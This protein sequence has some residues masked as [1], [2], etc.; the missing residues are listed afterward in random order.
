[1]LRRLS[2]INWR[3]CASDAHAH[4]LDS[5]IKQW[6]KESRPPRVQYI[7]APMIENNFEANGSN[8]PSLRISHRDSTDRLYH[9]DF[10]EWECIQQE[11]RYLP[12]EQVRPNGLLNVLDDAK[13]AISILLNAPFG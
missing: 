11:D 2:Q 5:R 4:E 6:L 8:E 10:V 3:E 12:F 7:S 9:P 1:M 13:A